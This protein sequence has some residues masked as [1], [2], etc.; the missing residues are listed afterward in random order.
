MSSTTST[1]PF[2][3]SRT[4]GGLI[5]LAILALLAFAGTPSEETP[6]FW[7]WQLIG[8]FHPILVHF[9]VVFFPLLFAAFLFRGRLKDSYPPVFQVLLA[10]SLFLGVLAVLSG[11]M[12]YQAGGYSGDLIQ[13]HRWG[14]TILVALATVFWISWPWAQKLA[15]GSQI[16]LAAMGLMNVILL[17][18]GHWGGSLTHGEAFLTEVIPQQEEP[19]WAESVS[20]PDSL[21]VYQ[22]VVA[23]ILEKKCL[24]CHNPHKKKGGLDMSTWQMLLEGGKSGKQMFHP[25]APDSGELLVRML[26]PGEV[27]EHMPPTGKPQLNPAE[28]GL[29]NSWIRHGADPRMQL[30]SLRA[31]AQDEV[32]MDVVWGSLGQ[33]QKEKQERRVQRATWESDLI[34]ET[35]KWGLR[36]AP[37]P[38]LDSAYFGVSMAMPP[39]YVNDEAILDLD[40]A[41]EGISRLS[42]VSAEIS[43]DGLFY[44]RKWNNLRALFLQKTCVEGPG[45]QYL[46]E[47]PALEVL[48]LSFTKV[49]DA[50]ALYLLKY[51]ALK[52]VYLFGTDVSPNVIQA[53]RQHMPE[54]EILEEEGPYF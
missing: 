27:D 51:P 19:V 43:D 25:T 11:Y 45:L 47:L 48:N 36:Y 54:T 22:A 26:L 41:A 3:I 33:Y 53:L 44:L 4:A 29:I 7:G 38:D 40:A 49:D 34:P 52:K 46:A 2:S 21:P 20:D 28:L 32:D 42:L 35:E 13:Q 6:L 16:G 17:L 14:A 10:A 37:D 1:T 24:S 12:L 30:A 39:A 18:T 50:S 15:Q 9:P 5:L 31:R 8:R 23:P